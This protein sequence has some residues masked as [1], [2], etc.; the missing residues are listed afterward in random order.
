M[1]IILNVLAM[2]MMKSFSHNNLF[3][4][5]TNLLKELVK[6][7]LIDIF[8]KELKSTSILMEW[9][10][11]MKVEYF[12]N[13]TIAYMRA[14]GAYDIQNKA[15]MEALKDYVRRNYRMDEQTVILGVALDDP[16]VTPSDQLRYDVGVILEEHEDIGL[17]TRKLDD[18]GYAIFEVPHTKQGVLAFWQDLA[19][20]TTGLSIDYNRVIIE[21]YAMKKINNHMCEF[22]IPIHSTSLL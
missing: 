13:I 6:N 10:K 5:K 7:I 4:Y 15:L 19:Q 8:M 3:L 1:F 9:R 17:A 18:G 22:C 14:V 11:A 16:S 20:V 2:G 21:R 12:K